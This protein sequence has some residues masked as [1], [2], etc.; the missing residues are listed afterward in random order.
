[1]SIYIP[2]S[3]IQR[4]ET[5]RSTLVWIRE[6]AFSSLVHESDG[7]CQTIQRLS[8]WTNF[9]NTR[10]YSIQDESIFQSTK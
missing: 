4:D 9:N 5:F 10:K 7:N 6:F 8:S 3:S 2:I 1:M